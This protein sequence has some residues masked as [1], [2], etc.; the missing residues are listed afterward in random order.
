MNVVLG[1]EK[2]P[3]HTK[4]SGNREDSSDT[5]EDTLSTEVGDINKDENVCDEAHQ[6]KIAYGVV[7]VC[8]DAVGV[9]DDH[10]Q[11]GEA[12]NNLGIAQT[13][14]KSIDTMNY[15][16]VKLITKT[17]TLTH[18]KLFFAWNIEYVRTSEEISIWKAKL[19]RPKAR[20]K[21]AQQLET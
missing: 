2:R 16:A 9:N 5:N 11:Q 14:E 17:S 21:P 13:M 18:E 3:C 15:A 20:L 6:H 4:D 12:S 19:P 7:M 1:L 8:W 10:N